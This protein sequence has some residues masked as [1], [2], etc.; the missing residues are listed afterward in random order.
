MRRRP[1]RPISSRRF[2]TT[3]LTTRDNSHA[4]SADLY[5][6]GFPCQPFSAAGKQQGFNDELGRGT[7]FF[8]VREY[9]AAQ[10]PKV[11]VLENVKGLVY[12]D[13]GRYFEAICESLESLQK[14]NL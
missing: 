10:T 11:F 6:A 13:G 4:A 8:K 1:Y 9:I 2:S 3:T 14:Y 5:V 12:I 7:I